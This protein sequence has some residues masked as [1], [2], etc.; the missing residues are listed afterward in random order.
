MNDRPAAPPTTRW[1]TPKPTDRAPGHGQTFGEWCDQLRVLSAKEPDRYG[2]DAIEAC[3]AE[4]WWDYY[5]MGYSPDD[6]WA[7]DGSYVE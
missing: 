3:G 1:T 4:C 7:E 2:A 5:E 6:A